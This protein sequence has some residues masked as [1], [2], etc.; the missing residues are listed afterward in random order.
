MND[1]AP[2]LRVAALQT[3]L[4]WEN[5]NA[6]AEAIGR[7]VG[8]LE[9]PCDLIVLP[10]MWATGFTM[11]PG[12]H[13]SVLPSGWQDDEATWPAPLTVMRKWA[14]ERDAALVGSLSCQDQALPH[15]VNRC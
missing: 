10:E 7:Q 9:E 15:P 3:P 4:V 5:P 1:S 13:A 8:A 14:R 6:N 12:A 11:D 2:L